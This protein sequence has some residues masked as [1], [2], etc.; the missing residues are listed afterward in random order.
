MVA[1]HK[2]IVFD[3]D[4]TLMDSAAR[5]VDSM[6]AA[7]ADA[8]LPVREPA[9]IR[10]II[11]LGLSEALEALY[12]GIGERD[13]AR[14]QAGYRHHFMEKCT[15]PARL[16][17]GAAETLAA[18]RERGYWLAVATGKSRAGL[19]R[20]LAETGLGPLFFASRCA[21][22]TRSKPD[23]M[24]LEE[25]LVDFDLA[26]EQALM[27]G[28]SEYDMLMASNA[29]TRSLA[30]SYG[31]HERERLMQHGALGCIDAIDELGTLMKGPAGA[32]A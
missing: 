25:I 31:V 9:A 28:D 4:G 15:T 13:F 8:G 30:V 23:P 18:L 22:E 10:E 11:G 20:M 27:V 21:D 24:M 29:G 17:E 19:D 26:P 2:L 7:M 6:Q 16:F 5:I 32:A 14:M 12:P 1:E 3:W